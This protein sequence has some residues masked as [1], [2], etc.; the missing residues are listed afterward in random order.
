NYQSYA[1]TDRRYSRGGSEELNALVDIEETTI[2]PEVRMDAFEQAEALMYDEAY[3]IYLW[4][5]DNLYATTADVEYTPNKIG[6]LWMF[7]AKP[8]E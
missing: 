5:M 3:F 1:R 4:Q 8:V 2:D 6:L 7:D